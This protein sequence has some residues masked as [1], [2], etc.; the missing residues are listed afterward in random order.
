MD[1]KLYPQSFKSYYEVST[2]Y[3]LNGCDQCY[4]TGYK[5]R[6]AVYE[7]IPLDRELSALVKSGEMNAES[8]LKQ[9]GIGSLSANAFDLFALGETTIE[10]IYPLL[11]N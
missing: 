9:K 3:V 2:Q 5:G 11:L 8:V 4:F 6:K 7:V 1:E 10:E